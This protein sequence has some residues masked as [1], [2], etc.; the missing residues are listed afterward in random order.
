MTSIS[1]KCYIDLKSS[2]KDAM[3]AAFQS[4]AFL[5]TAFSIE[6][7]HFA[8]DSHI[9]GIVTYTP[10]ERITNFAA[11]EALHFTTSSFK[12]ILQSRI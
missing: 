3:K 12:G 11:L 8:K 9:Q 2:G 1:C 6:Q 7:K 5:E 10:A 4:K